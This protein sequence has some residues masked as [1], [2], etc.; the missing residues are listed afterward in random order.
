MDPFASLRP[1]RSLALPLL[2]FAVPTLYFVYRDATGG[3]PSGRPCLGVAHAGYAV[4]ALA[5]SYLLAVVVTSLA[6]VPALAARHPYARLALRPTD[7]TLTVLAVL[8]VAIASYVLATLVATI[9]PWL[10]RALAPLG[11]VVGLPLVVA[12]G[13]LT[14]VGSAVSVE[15]SLAVQTAVVAAS[16]AATGVWLLGLATGIAGLLASGGALAGASR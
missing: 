6:D 15:P 1:R 13:G 7:R 12:Y 10:D 9:P 3:C 2:A 11:L 16:L 4:A 14:V 8:V 5:G